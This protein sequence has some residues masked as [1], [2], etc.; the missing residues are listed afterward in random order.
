[1]AD[2]SVLDSK[3]PYRLISNC[4][5]DE[6]YKE[7]FCIILFYTVKC[8]RISSSFGY[9]LQT[10]R[11]VDSCTIYLKAVLLNNDNKIASVPL[12]HAVKDL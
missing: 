6:E 8:C 7:F 5:S 3:K 11:I 1:M 2:I 10:I 12:R 4:N 9:S